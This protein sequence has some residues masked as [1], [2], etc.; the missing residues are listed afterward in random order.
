MSA[1]SGAAAAIGEDPVDPSV[2]ER[3][4]VNRLR[5]RWRE[6]VRDGL[7][8]SIDDIDP[9]VIGDDWKDCMLIAIGFPIESSRLIAIGEH[10]LAHPQWQWQAL[11]LADV[12]GDSLISVITARLHNVLSLRDC[13]VDEGGSA[14]DGGTILYRCTLLP[15][16]TDKTEIDH[17]LVAVNSKFVPPTGT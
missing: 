6:A 8:P 10:L 7:F 3:R 4:L 2:A 5:Q 16:A 11:S 14:R 1:Y 13:I 12:P 9:W 17:V 15:L